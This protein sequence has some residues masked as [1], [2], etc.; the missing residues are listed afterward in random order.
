MCLTG[1]SGRLCNACLH[2]RPDIHDSL[3]GISTE[4]VMRKPHIHDDTYADIWGRLL[5]YRVAV[6]PEV[7]Q[8]FL[9]RSCVRPP[10]PLPQ[11]VSLTLMPL[12]SA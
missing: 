11:S 8:A 6:R 2:I 1:L 12:G 3:R 4:E 5:G 7:F 9:G 10:C